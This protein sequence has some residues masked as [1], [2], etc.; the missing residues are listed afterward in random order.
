MSRRLPIIIILVALILTHVILLFLPSALYETY[1]TIIRPVAYIIILV[2]AQLSLPRTIKSY[3][4]K[5]TILM[6]SILGIVIYLAANF[7]LGLA[8]QFGHNSMNLSLL[9][10]LKN[11]WA[12]FVIIIFCEIIRSNIMTHVGEKRKYLIVAIVTVIFSFISLDSLQGIL[13]FD[14]FQQIDWF[15][16]V[17]LPIIATNL[18][19]T[20]SAMHGGLR[21]NLIFIL[22][23]NA[24]IYFSPILPDIPRILDAII[25]YCIVFIMFIVYDSVEWFSKR[26]SGI[27]IEYKDRRRWGWSIIPATFL[28]LCIMFGVGVFP[29][30]PVA[31]AS[32]SMVQEFRRGDMIYVERTSPDDLEV[33]NIVQYSQGNISV[34][35]RII[36]IRHDSTRGRYFIFQGDENP[37]PDIFPVYD[38]QIVGRVVA[39]TPLIGFP[40]LLFQGLKE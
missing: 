18:W 15:F 11:F 35:H 2:F 6:V 23:Y 1:F 33:G 31:V 8:M 9:G 34:V 19:L 25:T 28:V 4:G 12:F 39:K 22:S 32:N 29:V 40:A 27:T 21:G 36:E 38:D 14:M 7:I 10:I 24:L 26:H 30:M 13:R 3:P 20:Y 37:L 17:L 16:I 5:Q